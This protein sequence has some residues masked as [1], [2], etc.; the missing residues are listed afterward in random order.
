MSDPLRR[1]V[2]AVSSVAA[3]ACVVWLVRASSWGW[4]PGDSGDRWALAATTGTVVAAALLFGLTRWG[5]PATSP[6]PTPGGGRSVEQIAEAG[7][8]AVVEQIVGNRAPRRRGAGSVAPADR[9]R[10]RAK[11]TGSSRIRQTGGD[12]TP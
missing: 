7:D 8:Q 10:Q 3:F 1:T 12:D 11:G 6:A 5:S 4:L 9:F 2:A